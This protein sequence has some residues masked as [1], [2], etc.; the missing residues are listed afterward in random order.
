MLFI[1]IFNHETKREYIL[2]T[3]TLE[4]FTKDYIDFFTRTC[5]DADAKTYTITGTTMV[6][7]AS[8]NWVSRGYLYNSRK[9]SSNKLY[10][11]SL[12]KSYSET[13]PAV[14]TVPAVVA[15]K[16]TS[17]Q[18]QC[19]PQE[20]QTPHFTFSPRTERVVFDTNTDDIWTKF[21]DNNLKFI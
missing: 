18:Y 9:T 15:T 13:V 12:I 16:D 4:T 5:I 7:V 10:T 20:I 19:Q 21:F 8:R 3:T 2:K 14:T 6:I 17:S 11:L 1:N